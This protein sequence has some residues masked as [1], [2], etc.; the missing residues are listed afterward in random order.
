MIDLQSGNA[1][2]RKSFA[3]KEGLKWSH[4]NKLNSKDFPIEARKSLQ[5]ICRFG[6]NANSFKYIICFTRNLN[7]FKFQHLTVS[8][9]ENRYLILNLAYL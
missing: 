3:Y 8:R 6:E 9:S 4:S 1:G 5:K 2:Q 7:Y